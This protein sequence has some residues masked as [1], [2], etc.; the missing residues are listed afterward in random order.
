MYWPP[1]QVVDFIKF[2]P[3][4]LKK[5]GMRDVGVTPGETSNWFR[6][7]EWGYAHA[8]AD[9]PEASKNIGLITSHGF[10][11]SK[12]GR[13][14]GD[15]RSLGTDII[16]A[17]RPEIHCWI[18]STSWSQMD[19]FFVNEIYNNIYSAKLNGLIPWAAIQRQGKWVGGDPNPGTAFRVYD[20]GTF[21]VEPGYY[22]YKQ[23]CRAGQPGM[24]VCRVLSN[25]SEVGL[26]GFASNNTKNPDAFVVINVSDEGKD[27]DIE[28]SGG[29]SESFS[30][31][32]TS[33]DGKYFSLG[34]LPV[35]DG[36]VEYDAPK[37][38]VT[39]FYG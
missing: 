38:S 37:R 14:F 35:R 34:D 21:S 20:D 4:M 17:K 33:E 19:V 27:M 2:M 9:D 39:T 3:D 26:I 36:I 8:I 13:W 32:R 11:G 18:T 31:Y 30:A 25:D 23:V 15:W 22:F 1:E 28:V 16:R 5:Q 10:H 6:F 7:S 29:A 12:I 24:Y